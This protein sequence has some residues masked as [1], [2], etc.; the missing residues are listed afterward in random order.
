MGIFKNLF[1][2]KYEKLTREEV[3]DA[4]CKLEK[5][6]KEIE[7]GLISKTKQIEEL[8]KRGR[9]EKSKEVRLFYAKK[10]NALKAERE[11]SVQRS[12]Y[13][14]YNSQLLQRLK[15]AIDDNQFFQK[16]S[17]ISLGNL[18]SDQKGLAKFLN[19]TLGRRIAA[20]DVL[21][22]A[23]ETFREVESAYVK[24]ETIYG[25]DEQD[26]ALLA[27]FETED[28]VDSEKEVFSKETESETQEDIEK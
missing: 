22:S 5:E 27:L 11:Q 12:M 9:A 2:R 7:D 25:I 28:Q 26:D 4:I 6:G 15:T 18:L 23:D 20:E 10:I 3:V 24:N 19:K 14:M 16:T 13:L 8:M 17:K 1:K 21:T